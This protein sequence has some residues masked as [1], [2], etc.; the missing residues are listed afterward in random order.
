MK[1]KGRAQGRGLGG[2]GDDDND[3]MDRL[4]DRDLVEVAV[5]L[6]LVLAP[7][8][9]SELQEAKLGRITAEAGSAALRQLLLAGLLLR[10][11]GEGLGSKWLLDPRSARVRLRCGGGERQE[12]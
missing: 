3:D 8:D 12:G 5:A 7:V 11:L 4:L 6:A 9:R 2:V 10:S 1:R